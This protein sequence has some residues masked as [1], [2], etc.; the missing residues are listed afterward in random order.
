MVSLPAGLLLML[1]IACLVLVT[2]I[3]SYSLAPYSSAVGVNVRVNVKPDARGEFLELIEAENAC[4]RKE[5]G[6]LQAII[7]EDTETENMFHLHKQFKSMADFES[8][9]ERDYAKA[10]QDFIASSDG[11]EEF[12][13]DLFS[14]KNQ[15][16]AV[17]PQRDAYC[18]N[19]AL[20]IKPEHRDAF[21][22]VIDNNMKGTRSTEPLALQYDWGANLKEAGVSCLML[23]LRYS[24]LCH[25]I[26]ILGF[27]LPRGVQRERWRKRGIQCTCKGTSL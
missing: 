5:P 3:V 25:L 20:Y 12:N 18:L 15:D 22:K 10:V 21:L 24:C 11:I 16:D 17:V 19:V 27:S 8:H 7:G 23:L 9:G 6:C 13:V 4:T 26:I 2:P 1:L 14:C